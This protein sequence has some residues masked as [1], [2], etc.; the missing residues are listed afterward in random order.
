MNDLN[1]LDTRLP[2]LVDGRNL[3]SQVVRELFFSFPSQIYRPANTYIT[4]TVER[5][6]Y[7]KSSS[8]IDNVQNILQIVC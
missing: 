4:K 3:W 6:K 7:D 1:R 5:V 2:S 8:N